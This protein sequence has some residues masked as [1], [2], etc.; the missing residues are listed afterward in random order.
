MEKEGIDIQ[1][2]PTDT[3]NGYKVNDI[4]FRLI[5]IPFFGITIPLVTGMINNLNLSNW[6]VK[7]S[8]LY[9]IMIA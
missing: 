8:F 4:G 6:Q 5:L 1:K 9:T 2:L 3:K 7:L